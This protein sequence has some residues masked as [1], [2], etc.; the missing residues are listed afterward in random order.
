MCV[1]LHLL[2]AKSVIMFPASLASGI[3]FKEI[4]STSVEVDG[5]HAVGKTVCK[6]LMQIHSLTFKVSLWYEDAFLFYLGIAGN[7]TCFS[8]YLFIFCV[9]R[10]VSM[11]VIMTAT[12]LTSPGKSLIA[13][14]RR[15]LP[16][17]LDHL[18]EGVTSCLHLPFLLDVILCHH[19]HPWG[20]VAHPVHWEI[21]HHLIVAVQTT[22]YSVVARHLLQQHHQTDSGDHL[23]HVD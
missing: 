2:V 3:V 15:F 8:S 23:N 11:M 21:P 20:F 18:Y 12:A 1:H 4:F 5:W 17:T 9:G 19:P 7:V 13:A 6:G 22:A 14:S 10:I 16:V